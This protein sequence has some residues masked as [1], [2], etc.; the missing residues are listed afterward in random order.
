MLCLQVWLLTVAD[1]DDEFGSAAVVQRLR[2]LFRA[3]N[4]K[5]AVSVVDDVKT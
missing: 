1:G 2:C 4:V 3:R 5:I